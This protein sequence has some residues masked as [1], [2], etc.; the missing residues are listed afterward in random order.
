M[1][2]VVTEDHMIKDITDAQRFKFAVH[3][4]KGSW[5]HKTP[6]VLIDELRR[7]VNEL[8]VCVLDGC[9]KEAIL[10][11]CADIANYV[12]MLWDITKNKQDGKTTQTTAVKCMGDCHGN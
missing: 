2:D 8:E 6:K 3:Q 9:T 5:R 10:S 1:R 12:A 4:S 11:E 7:E